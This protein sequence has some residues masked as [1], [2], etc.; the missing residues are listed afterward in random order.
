MFCDCLKSSAAYDVHHVRQSLFRGSPIS[1]A[2][3]NCQNKSKNKRYAPG[4]IVRLLT[5]VSGSYHGLAETK[6]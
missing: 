5:K 4:C 3:G 2:M 1:M 6:S